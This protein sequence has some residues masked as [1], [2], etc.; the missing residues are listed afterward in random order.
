MQRYQ[1]KA[2]FTIYFLAHVSLTKASAAAAAAAAAKSLQSCLALCDLRDGR[3]TRLLCPWDSPGKNTGVHCHFLLQG[4]LPTQRLNS[5]LPHCG[6]ILYQLSHKG[7]PWY[8]VRKCSNFI[9]LHVAVQFSQ[10]HLLKRLSL[11]H[12]ISLPPLSK[13]RYP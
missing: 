3:P 6:Q 7:S 4:I 9:L 8:G 2:E 12:C 10:H 11:P 13:I 1:I 5:G